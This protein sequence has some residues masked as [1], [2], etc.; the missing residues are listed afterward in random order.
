MNDRTNR[1][2]LSLKK[3]AGYKICSAMLLMTGLAFFNHESD[4]FTI[5]VPGPG[6]AGGCADLIDHPQQFRR[7]RSGTN[8]FRITQNFMDRYPDAF[9]Q[10]LVE[11]S[12]RLLT[13]FMS[14]QRY[15]WIDDIQQRE[16]YLK[17]N[18]SHD[19]YGLKGVLIHEFSHALG[20]QHNDGCYYN[21]N[22]ETGD[23]WL[24]NYELIG[25]G[26]VA[27]VEPSGLE[28]MDGE[29]IADF[30]TPD[31]DVF[32]FFTYAYPFQQV[33]FVRTNSNNQVIRVDSTDA[34]SYGGQLTVTD[35]QRIDP[36][37]DNQGWYINEANL[38]V[39]YDNFIL[40]KT[41]YWYIDNT[42]GHDINQVTLRINGTS[43]RKPID[44]EAPD[45]FSHLGIGTTSSPE[46]LIYS[47]TT[48]PGEYWPAPGGI[49][50]IPGGNPNTEPPRF[51][52]E[53]D[54]YQTVVQ[55]V[56]L[57]HHSNQ[58]FE[59]VFPT[60][61]SI[62]P[63]QFTPNTPPLA[64]TPPHAMALLPL[65]EPTPAPVDIELQALPEPIDPYQGRR[66]F[67]L[68]IPQVDQTIFQHI[69]LLK[70]SWREAEILMHQPSQQRS[71]NLSQKFVE[72]SDQIQPL[73]DP[74]GH[75][76][77]R[78][79]GFRKDAT[80]FIPDPRADRTQRTPLSKFFAVNLDD[81]HTYATRVVVSS[82]A[83]VVYH[84]TLPEMNRYMGS[85]TARCALSGDPVSCCPDEMG[86]PILVERSW[87]SENLT[88]S[89]CVV[90]SALSDDVILNGR[91]PHLLATGAGDDKVLVDRSESTVQ[92]GTGNDY[93]ATTQDVAAHAD[94]GPG[95]DTLYGSDQN[96]FLTG[97][98][99]P[100]TLMAGAGDDVLK[101]GPG[102]DLIMAGSGNDS[103]YPGLGKNQVDAGDGDDRVIF[104]HACELKLG[105]K[106]EGGHGHD[107]LYLP[108]SLE[109]A[110]TLG[111][112]QSGFEEVI[113]HAV[114]DSVIP[115]CD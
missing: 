35:T 70:M 87:T 9:A 7:L 98:D 101:G 86:D 75:H 1:S 18:Y 63:W 43:T 96:D 97:G 26:Q 64:M 23:P 93:F 12:A 58:A 39:G 37:D 66:G 83:G 91:L 73:L 42:S 6:S 36:N 10:Y 21:I 27:V 54:A 104:T 16:H 15:S 38:W 60:V 100:D 57:W 34:D 59:V 88:K 45:D 115:T 78:S 28:M 47:W 113:E 106:L 31:L 79:I 76:T 103:I 61:Q 25:G 2:G 49:V 40:N 67:Q 30:I 32:D 82:P 99:G 11:D 53:L 55:E 74:N 95:A 50:G 107:T 3:P 14:T 108:I 112:I 33:D 56:L 110:K 72:N 48:P 94:G 41:N 111:L 109:H 13:D 90:G 85:R 102:N 84:Y 46:Q 69:D 68:V 44:E 65:S 77:L 29:P 81:Q 92:L 62:M 24:S 20:M 8:T 5:Q 51:F 80:L 19:S 4:A 17:L 114:R 105:S 71:K 22:Q 89:S 52:L